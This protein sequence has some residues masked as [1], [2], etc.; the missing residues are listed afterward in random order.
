MK[1]Y[2]PLLIIV[3]LFSCSSTALSKEQLLRQKE[4]KQH[5]RTWNRF[6]DSLV[7]FH[8]YQLANHSVRTTEKNGGYGGLHDSD[9]FYR[10]VH[11]YEKN[12]GKLLSRVQWEVENPE[13]IHVIE[14]FVYDQ[15]NE[16]ARDYLVAWL[17]GFRNAPIQTLVNL[18]NK[19]DELTAFRQFDASGERIYETCSGKHFNQDVDISIEDYELSPFAPERPAVMSTEAYTECFGSLP[20][21]AGV[22]LN[23]LAGLPLAAQRKLTTLSSADQSREGIELHVK[24]LTAEISA[25][26]KRA[27]LY[28]ERGDLFF[29][30]H[31]FDK[32]ISDYSSAI[33]LDSSLGQAWFG[34]G[35]ARGRHGQVAAGIADLSVFIKQNPGSSLA[36][37]KRG[38]RHIWNDDPT[39][40]EQ[41]LR[42]AIE[43]DATNAEAHDDLGV[44]LAQRKQYDEAI[45]HLQQTIKHDPAYQKGF[46]NLATVYFITGDFKLALAMVNQ[47]LALD[48]ASRDSLLLKGEVL[49]RLGQTE[50]AQAII[51]EAEFLPESNWS[52]ATSIK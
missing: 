15:D 32:A 13:T 21:S 34:R 38:V 44:I 40:A 5:I 49:A 30:L 24:Q 50:A 2:L 9:N 52:E 1:R 14:V 43:L 37:T 10:E 27:E 46:H 26:P 4:D 16:L 3:S 18:H 25:L 51:E 8:E 41:D 19:T 28:I 11:Y 45:S 48:P 35:M 12:S 39:R 29:K 22:Y 31:A 33:K 20:I 6:A 7:K 47:G 23:P 36:Y 17:P 42:R